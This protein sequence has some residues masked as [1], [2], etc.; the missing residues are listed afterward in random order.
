MFGHRW[1]RFLPYVRIKLGVLGVELRL[2]VH[3]VD[4][5]T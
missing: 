1:L 5:G 4:G 2:A 3:D